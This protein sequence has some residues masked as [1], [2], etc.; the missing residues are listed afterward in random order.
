MWGKTTSGSS[1]FLALGKLKNLAKA[2]KVGWTTGPLNT[3]E[4]QGRR[5]HLK[6]GGSSEGRGT[7]FSVTFNVMVLNFEKIGA[8]ACAGL[9]PYSSS[10]PSS[11]TPLMNAVLLLVSTSSCER[12]NLL[13]QQLDRWLCTSTTTFNTNLYLLS[14]SRPCDI[15]FLIICDAMFAQVLYCNSVM[16]LFSC[17]IIRYYGALLHKLSEVFFSLTN[18]G[19]YLLI[20]CKSKCLWKKKMF[21]E[22]SISTQ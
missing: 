5:S 19:W 3:N 2:V 15:Y 13:S 6:K 4:C 14:T 11:A 21:N 17:S 18:D 1:N 9:S 12:K 8:Q 20:Y 16:K 22:K 7:L 10:Y